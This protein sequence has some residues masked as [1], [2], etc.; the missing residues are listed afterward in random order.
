MLLIS[1]CLPSLVPSRP[2]VEIKAISR[3]SPTTLK[4][5]WK[6]VPPEFTHGTVLKYSVKYQ[7]V[8]V[9]DEKI[10]DDI[11]LFTVEG[12]MNLV[13][14]TDLDPYVEYMVSVAAETQKGTGPYAF[15]TGGICRTSTMFWQI[16]HSSE[17][18]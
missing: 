12:D 7:R 18:V 4:V 14:L 13:K 2:P 11:K 16:M 10:E 6:P 15:V 5:T 8:K 9:G 1:V 3:L 17:I